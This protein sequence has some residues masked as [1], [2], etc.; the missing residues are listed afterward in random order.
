MVLTSSRKSFIFDEKFESYHVL[1]KHLFFLPKLNK[2]IE[3]LN[4]NSRLGF[5]NGFL[6]DNNGLF[7]KRIKIGDF[8]SAVGEVRY[9]EP[10]DYNKSAYN[11]KIELTFDTDNISKTNINLDRIMTGY[12][13][14]SFQP[15]MDLMKEESKEKALKSIIKSIKEEVEIDKI[16]AINASPEKFGIAPLIV[17]AS[18]TSESLVDNAGNKFLFKVGELIGP[19]LEMYQEN[20]RKLKVHEDFKRNYISEINI[21]IPKGYSFKNLEALNIS[22]S[23]DNEGKT[24]FSFKSGY[25]LDGNV[26]KI[27][28]KEFYNKNIIDIFHYESYRKVINSAANFNKVVLIMIINN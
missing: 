18:I 15:Y 16:E 6:T 4:Y 20:D 8:E 5:P 25:T 23:Y 1:D 11:L 13:A 27:K 17:K 14:M 21:N 2:Y 12:Y 19:Q 3:P 26:L 9:I 28:I 22:E 10:V 24:Y 7:I